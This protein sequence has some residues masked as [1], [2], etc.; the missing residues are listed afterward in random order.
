MAGLFRILLLLGLVVK[1]WW[2]VLL[3]LVAA[4]AGLLLWGVVTRHDAR[5]AAEHREQAA[6]VARAE[7]QHARVLAGDDRGTYGD[8]L[9]SRAIC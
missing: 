6:L 5:V 2:L 3:V 4:G 1:F 9:V 7:Q 8:V